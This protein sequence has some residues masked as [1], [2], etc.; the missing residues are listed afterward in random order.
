MQ[1]S[2]HVKRKFLALTA[3]IRKEE[4][5]KINETS[6]QHKKLEKGQENTSNK[7]EGRK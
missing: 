3:H 2:Q 5:L 6:T 1:L 7:I 4:R